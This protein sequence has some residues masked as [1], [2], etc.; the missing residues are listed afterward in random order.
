MQQL[1][2]QT[3]A[4]RKPPR[5]RLRK[6]TLGVMVVLVVGGWTLARHIRTWFTPAQAIVVLG[7]SL[8][9]ESFAAQ[10]ATQHPEMPLWVSSGSNPEYAERIYF[11]K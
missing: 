2:F 3:Q 1:K 5:R 8:D 10:L 7:G 9:R 11:E 6:R 4:S